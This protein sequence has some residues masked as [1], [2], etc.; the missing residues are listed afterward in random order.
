MSP[1]QNPEPNKLAENMMRL[2][3]LS[4]EAIQLVAQ[5]TANQQSKQSF[6]P[7]NIS[8]AFMEI[9]QEN[10]ANPEKM[11]RMQMEFYQDYLKLMGNITNRMLGET[12]API[13]ALKGKDNRFRDESWDNNLLFSYLKQY[14]IMLSDN[15]LRAVQD[16]D[17]MDESSKRKVEFYTKQFIDAISP[18]NYPFSNPEVIKATIDTNGENLINGFE[19]LLE[20]L[21]LGK[22]STTDFNAFEIGKNIACTNGKVV[23]QNDLIQLIQYNPTTEKTHEIPLL[24]I[25]AWINKYYIL[26]LKPENSLVKWIL[27]QGYSLFII[28]WRNPNEKLADKSFEH[29]MQEGVLESIDQILKI[30]GAKQIS[31][32]GYCL[33]GTLLACSLAYMAAKGEDKVKNVTF[34]TT[35][36]DFSDAGDLLVFIDEEQISALEQRMSERGYL[37]GSQM[38]TTFSM[39]RSNDMIWS[40]VVNNYLLGKDPFPFDIL[41][42]NADST[43]LPAKMHSFYL[44]NMYQ[45]NLLVKKGG[46]KL[47]GVEIDLSKI[48][49]P[50]YFLST[51][52][53]HI[54]PWKS[55]FEG[56]KLLGGKNRFVLSASGH[57]AGIVNP[58]SKQKYCY[59]VNDK[60]DANPDKW[61]QNVSEHAGSWWVDWDKWNAS[62]A[63][64]KITPPKMGKASEEAPGSFVKEKI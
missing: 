6:D 62:L 59:W 11:M 21:K 43:R 40:F 32:M 39:L 61:L 36:I 22:I 3:E 10:I 28:S 12:E 37:D 5:K 55:T 47:N 18:S 31:A 34:L 45:K 33:G 14:Y 44:R 58:P 54:A 50:A 41:Y 35:L 53:D 26:D 16:T 42:W 52:E 23:Y 8:H 24:I 57:V 15:M 46:V 48:K 38:A 7:F 27:D 25:P 19:N 60:L 49:V 20:D 13:F 1:A 56:T 64:E 4:Q 29:Y 17:N 30:T 63:G 9:L 2:A 51:K